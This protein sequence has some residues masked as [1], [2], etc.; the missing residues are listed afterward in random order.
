M[1]DIE[2]L[3]GIL[4]KK[5][6]QTYAFSHQT[7]QEYLTAEAL[8]TSEVGWRKVLTHIAEPRWREVFFIMLDMQ[9]DTDNFA[10]YLQDK[11]YI[12]KTDYDN[13]YDNSN[14]NDKEWKYPSM[15][16]PDLQELLVKL[17][18]KSYTVSNHSQY[19][20]VAIRIFYFNCFVVVTNFTLGR[21]DIFDGSSWVYENGV[22][23]EDFIFKLASAMDKVFPYIQ[24]NNVAKDDLELAY[25]LISSFLLASELNL[26]YESED[27]P[28][29][30]LTVEL[31]EKITSILHIVTNHYYKIDNQQLCLFD[32]EPPQQTI[33]LDIPYNLLQ[34]LRTLKDELPAYI[35][36]YKFLIEWWSHYGF[37]WYQD[38]RN[39]I[40]EQRNIG[41]IKT[42]DYFMDRAVLEQYYEANKIL[43]DC[44]NSS[45]VS[46]NLRLLIEENIFLPVV[47]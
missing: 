37:S 12:L 26:F 40:I 10:R 39:L 17:N 32:S 11:F 41:L 25:L 31:Q 34:S 29:D 42:L 6:W 13:W 3:S 8:S 35:D 30:D 47:L 44:L 18:H 16:D 33:F 21:N 45:K 46:N 38:F 28:V 20:P 4:V 2:V 22:K 24:F 14:V 43:V 15:S 7:F 19:K 27:T 23:Q 36:D 1:S 9:P 5:S